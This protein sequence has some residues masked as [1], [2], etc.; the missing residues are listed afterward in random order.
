MPRAPRWSY[1]TRLLAAFLAAALPTFA[2]FTGVVLYVFGDGWR[3]L[4]AIASVAIATLLL[5][6]ALQRRAVFPLYTLT[7]L[8]EA[9]REGDYSLRGSRGRRGDVVGEVVWEINALEQTLREQRLSVEEKSALLTK[10]LAAL[11]IAVL[12]FD[13]DGFLALANPA[14][15]RLLGRPF[16]ALD[17]RSAQALGLDGFLGEDSLGEKQSRVVEHA[18]PGGNGRWGIRHARFRADGRPHDLLVVTDLSRALREEERLAWQR[19]L[20]VLGHELNNSLAPIR[21]MAETVARLL[22]NEQLPDDWRDDARAGLGVIADRA[23]ALARFMARYT[24]LARLPPPNR[25]E[26]AF[27]ELARRTARLEQRLE[28]RIA[29]SPSVRASIDADQIEQVLINLIRNAV[30]AV[31]GNGGDVSLGWRDEN[32]TLVVDLVDGGPGL[33]PSG[34]LFVPFF[35]T[36]P[37]GSGIGLVLARQIVEQH[38]GSLSLANRDDARGCIARIELPLHDT[39]T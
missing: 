25:R 29:E 15:E 39:A 22:G 7:N 2:A 30:D 1:E 12:S 24:Q 36:K 21:S 10:V 27:D 6:I 16:P 34:N 19:L 5:A 18:F 8:L 26:V 32:G 38:G 3:P 11:D 17:G 37:G 28:V 31:L 14:A 35:T 9:L 13:A 33:P 4:L 23:D 20:R